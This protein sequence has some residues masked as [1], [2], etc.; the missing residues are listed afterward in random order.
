MQ[1]Y[2]EKASLKMGEIK[3]RKAQDFL[4]THGS[5][6]DLDSRQNAGEGLL[7]RVVGFVRT[8]PGIARD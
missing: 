6:R 5:I 1:E 2:R 4:N 7:K 8:T 3:R